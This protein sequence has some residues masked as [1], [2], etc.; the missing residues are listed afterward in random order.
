M[1]FW[2]TSG[3]NPSQNS[4]AFARGLWFTMVVVA[5]N[6]LLLAGCASTPS[7]YYMPPSDTNSQAD[8]AAFTTDAMTINKAIPY[9]PDW[10]HWN[11]Y[12]KQCSVM[13]ERPYNAIRD[14]ACTEPNY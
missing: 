8:G 9:R 4:A 14:Y 3:V 10:K 7:P 11:F 2:F 13:D 12:Y 5:L 1:R 6:G